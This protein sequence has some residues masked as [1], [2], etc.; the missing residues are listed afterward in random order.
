VLIQAHA[1]LRR[2]EHNVGWISLDDG[3]KDLSRFILYLI[4]AVRRTG[5]K[6]GQALTALLGTGASLPVDTLKTLML[7]ELATLDQEFYLILDDYHLVSDPE[8][9]DLVNSVLLSPIQQL[10]LLIS[11]RTLNELPVS[12]LRALGQIQEVELADL[13][14]SEFE[15][16]EFVSKVRGAPLSNAQVARL[17]EETEGWAASLQMAGIALRGVSEVDVFLDRFSGE[18]KSVGDFLGEEVLQRQPPEVQEFMTFTSILTRFNW[19]LCNAVTGLADGRAMIDEL[20]RRNLFIFSLD[21][22]HH[23]YRY[24]HLFSDFLRRRL[25]ERYPDRVADCHRRASE[26]LAEHRFMTDA[27]EHAFDANDIANAGELLDRACADLF[28]AGQTATLMSLSS[29]LPQETLDRL[30]RLQLERAWYSELSWKFSDA[31]LAL[32]RVQAA[33]AERA[34]AGE[35]SGCPERIFLDAKL[36]HRVM[37]LAFL[38][39][40][41]PRTR[42]LAGAWID[43]EKTQDPFMCASAGSASMAS[44]RELFHCEGVATSARMLH[45]RFIEGG[46]HYGIVFHQSI[47]GATFSER[48]DLDQAQEA[49]ERALQVA[50]ELHGEHSALYNMPSLMFSE[51]YYERN[52]LRQAEEALA[53]R[54]ISSEL[55]FVDNLIAGFITR[56]KLLA[57]RGRH[58]QAET[59]L[60]EGGW[61]ATQYRFDRMQGAILG[62]RVRLLSVLGRG[63]EAQSLLRDPKYVG[64]GALVT[65]PEEGATRRDLY[66]ALASARVWIES[67]SARDGVS[68]LKPWFTFVRGRHCYRSAIRTGVL[69]ARALNATADRRAAQRML[70]ECLS[71]GESGHFIRTFVDEGNEL[72][73]LLRELQKNYVQQGT[74]CSLR[75]IETILAAADNPDAEERPSPVEQLETGIVSAGPLSQREVQILDLGARG[76]QNVDIAESLFLA[77][78]TVK[79][80]WQRIFDK[81]DVRRRPDAIK[82]ARQ[83]QWLP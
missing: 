54:D 3:D 47:V 6:F 49:Y 12:R 35:A 34:S 39:D 28:A 76:L 73:E 55:G 75:Y 59:V 79:W 81:L 31:R 17:R 22:E 68:L 82:R 20:E 53:Q 5:V 43:A 56:A 4:D 32:E 18:H 24:H 33:L 26:W 62:E 44:N 70:M 61:L 23:W 69:L 51:L 29:R 25:K 1:Q 63:K 14:F 36:A 13:T 78:S 64:E 9:R 41:M 19:S 48:G 71:L 10:H 2:D 21:L 67:G 60:E 11:S 77:E 52:Q 37:M 8:I 7:N 38:S 45:G 27:I 30:P 72:I 57:V 46:A 16:G 50:V 66:R 42:E 83:L 58:A 74:S 80:Y 15:V 40:D 65:A